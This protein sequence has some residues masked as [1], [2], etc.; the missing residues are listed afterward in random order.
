MLLSLS[1]AFQQAL[2]FND[3]PMAVA[4]LDVFPAKRPSFDLEKCDSDGRT[5]LMRAADQGKL[6]PRFPP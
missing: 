3:Q 4:L 6:I 5:L 2:V 1:E